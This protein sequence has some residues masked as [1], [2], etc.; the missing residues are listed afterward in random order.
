M[1]GD[2]FYSYA[3]K[4]EHDDAALLVPA[5]LASEQAAEVRELA[6]RAML[7]RER[8]RCRRS[9]SIPPD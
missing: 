9:P 5:P 2:E 4:Y 1:P 6:V 8:D 3:D 7:S